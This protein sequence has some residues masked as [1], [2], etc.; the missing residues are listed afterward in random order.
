MNVTA[1][2]VSVKKARS[3]SRE[4]NINYVN[5]RV[6]GNRYIYIPRAGVEYLALYRTQVC[7]WKYRKPSKSSGNNQF[8]A[9]C[10]ENLFY[11]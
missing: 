9:K 11:P 7:S 8:M 3:G 5:G 2:F 1:Y 6:Q 10:A 4:P